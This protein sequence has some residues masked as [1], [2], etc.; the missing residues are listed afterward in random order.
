LY[1][2]KHPNGIEWYFKQRVMLGGDYKDG[3][4]FVK[5]EGF[6]HAFTVAAND[7][8]ANNRGGLT[9]ALL[10][11]VTPDVKVVP[12]SAE[13]GAPFVAPTLAD[14]A[15]HRYPL[16]RYVYVFINRPP[17]KPIEP[18]TKEFLKLV[19]SREGQRVVAEEGVYIPLTAEVVRE[20]L[21]KLE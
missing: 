13:P 8:A 4:Q 2:L 16:S 20:E 21:A 9:Y 10:A 19:L 3:I 15:S 11:N 1:G 14:V 18:K 17:G 12:L 7:I 5:G 6:T